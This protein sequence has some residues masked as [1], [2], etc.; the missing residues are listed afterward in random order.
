MKAPR[1]CA[2]LL[3]TAC[4]ACTSVLYR[5]F[6][7]SE[8][9]GGR[10]GGGEGVGESERGGETAGGGEKARR[11]VK[12]HRTTS[13]YCARGAAIYRRP[14]EPPRKLH[15]LTELTDRFYCP[16]AMHDQMI[17]SLSL[18]F[19]SLPTLIC[20]TLGS[21]DLLHPPTRPPSALPH[22]NLTCALFAYRSF[23]FYWE[24]TT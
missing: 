18:S 22:F 10:E 15:H 20:W 23:N 12:T 21:L 19:F 4:G 6:A 3:F 5:P 1:D 7:K 24:G 9:E 14:G 16:S 8:R 2:R 11:L 13:G 17:L